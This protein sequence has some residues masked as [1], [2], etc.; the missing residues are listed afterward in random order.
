MTPAV[1]ESSNHVMTGV[2]D[3][4]GR[5]GIESGRQAS[6]AKSWVDAATEVTH[7]V[8]ETGVDGVDSARRFRN[9]ARIRVR[10]GKDKI[11]E[12]IIGRIPRRRGHDEED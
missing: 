11:A 7:K 6:D 1:V 5:L 9:D 8:R 12:E 3:F 2:H 4:R 10:P